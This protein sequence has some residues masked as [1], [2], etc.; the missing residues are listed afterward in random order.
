MGQDFHTDFP[1]TALFHAQHGKAD[2]F[3]LHHI[4]FPVSGEEAKLACD[5]AAERVV[6]AL[7]QIGADEF[8]HLVK[9]RYAVDRE[10]G[11]VDFGDLLIFIVILILNIADNAF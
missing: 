7:R 1:N 11:V 3:I 5:E 8:I 6:I 2:I 10:G 9:I 4:H